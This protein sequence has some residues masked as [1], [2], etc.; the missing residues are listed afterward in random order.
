MASRSIMTSRQPQETA[1]I[2]NLPQL[3]YSTIGSLARHLKR[4]TDHEAQQAGCLVWWLLGGGGRHQAAGRQGGSW[5]GGGG[6]IDFKLCRIHK[7]K[8]HQEHVTL[9]TF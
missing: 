2:L 3:Q 7:N 1:S 6:E 4:P 5:G 9:I 8:C